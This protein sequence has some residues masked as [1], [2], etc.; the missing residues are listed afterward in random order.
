MFKTY[1][2]LICHVQSG[3]LTTLE[4]CFLFKVG[5]LL[6]SDNGSFQ[7]LGVKSGVRVSVTQVLP[8]AGFEFGLHVSNINSN[9]TQITQT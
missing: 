6:L 8:Y 4:Q 1:Y 3:A 7:V 2:E 9:S 5:T